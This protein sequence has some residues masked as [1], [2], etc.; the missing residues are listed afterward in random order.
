MCCRTFVYLQAACVHLCMNVCIRVCISI[1][2]FLS[3]T[4]FSSWLSPLTLF[5]ST[6]VF[7]SDVRHVT[8]TCVSIFISV[9][10]ALSAHTPQKVLWSSYLSLF[11]PLSSVF[12]V[13][14]AGTIWLLKTAAA[15]LTIGCNVLGH[16]KETEHFLCACTKG[17]QR[18]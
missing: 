11:V 10:I 12:A 1:S 9:C 14:M 6:K 4:T 7:I 3:C 5:M 2:M 8:R 17:T 13:C 16:M 15:L 18:N